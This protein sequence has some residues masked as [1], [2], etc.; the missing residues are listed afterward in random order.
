M[1]LGAVG[2]TQVDVDG[3]WT[4]SQQFAE[5][6]VGARYAVTP[7]IHLSFDV[8]AG[9]RSVI[10]EDDRV[11]LGASAR[12]VAPPADEAEAYTSARLGATLLF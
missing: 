10:E 9:G 1:L 12:T 8:R 4:G 5:L 2:V 11:P 3:S 7:R 6:G